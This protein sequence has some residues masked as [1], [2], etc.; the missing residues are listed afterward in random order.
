MKNHNCHHYF[1]KHPKSIL[2][3]SPFAASTLA[4]PIPRSTFSRFIPRRHSSPHTVR[5]HT[6]PQQC[7][8]SVVV[9][10]E[11]RIGHPPHLPRGFRHLP[12]LTCANK[13]WPPPWAQLIPDLQPPHKKELR[14]PIPA[15][16]V[17]RQPLLLHVAPRRW[18]GPQRRRE[19]GGGLGGDQPCSNNA[20]EL[21][22]HR[23]CSSPIARTQF[24]ILIWNYTVIIQ[25]NALILRNTKTRSRLLRKKIRYFV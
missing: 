22:H 13:L 21:C 2:Q 23:L 8:A 25:N 20:T 15:G 4:S 14:V 12:L 17:P 6:M 19:V 24:F 18:Y 1:R 11:C 5:W 9:L 3:R 10:H 7:H 16:T